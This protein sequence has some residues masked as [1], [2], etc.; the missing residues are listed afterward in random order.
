MTDPKETANDTQVQQHNAGR[1]N[2]AERDPNQGSDVGGPAGG[3]QTT[4][5]NGL[6]QDSS[7]GDSATDSQARNPM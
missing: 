5:E 7:V 2:S 1:P 4:A 3:I 6:D